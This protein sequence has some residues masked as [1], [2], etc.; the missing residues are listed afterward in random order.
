MAPDTPFGVSLLAGPWFVSAGDVVDG[1]FPGSSVDL[2]AILKFNVVEYRR[3]C[4]K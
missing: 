4:E 1:V 3:E 2:E